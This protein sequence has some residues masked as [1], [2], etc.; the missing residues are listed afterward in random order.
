LPLLLRTGANGKSTFLETL[1]ELLGEGE[2]AKASQP[3]LLLSKKQD[4]HPVELAD[5]RGMRLVTTVEAGE[6]R[7]WDEVR[8]KWLTGG[9]TISARLMYGNPFSFTPNRQGRKCRIPT[10]FSNFTITRASAEV[11]SQVP[12]FRHSRHTAGRWR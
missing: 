2:Y 9:D 1:R 11:S 8:V 12:H 10:V 5:L 6:S 4:R 7:A 3:D